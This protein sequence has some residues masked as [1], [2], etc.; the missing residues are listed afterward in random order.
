MMCAIIAATVVEH[1]VPPLSGN[2]KHCRAIKELY[3]ITF[4]P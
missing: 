1:N 2:A 3:L 4:T